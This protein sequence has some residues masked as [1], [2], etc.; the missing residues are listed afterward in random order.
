MLK[1]KKAELFQEFCMEA[2]Q[3]TFTFIIAEIVA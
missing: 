2:R 3:G 1:T